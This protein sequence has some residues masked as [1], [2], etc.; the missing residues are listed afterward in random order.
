MK[1]VPQIPSPPY[2]PV[3]T[4]NRG[5]RSSTQDLLR[6]AAA[7]P[8]E[9]I[10]TWNP[11]LFEL[12]AHEWAF[13]CVQPK[14]GKV[15]WAA[16]SGDKGRDIRAYVIDEQ[17]E[18][19]SY[20]CKRYANKL[21]PSEAWIEL[22]KLC[23]YSY[24]GPLNGGYRCPRKFYFVAQHGVGQS[25]QDLIEAPNLLMDGLIA[26]WNDKCREKITSTAIELEGKLLEYVRQFPFQI[27]SHRTPR[28][29]VKDIEDTPYYPWFF[30][31]RKF[32]RDPI[33]PI[34]DAP[35]AIETKYVRALIHAY[36]EHLKCSPEGFGVT[37][38][39]PHEEIK[40]H[41]RESRE[42]FFYA[43]QLLRLGRDTFPTGT[44][45]DIL[46]QMYHGVITTVRADYAD[47]YARVVAVTE[48]AGTVVIGGNDLGQE[49]K[50]QDRTGLCHY[51]ANEGELKWVRKPKTETPND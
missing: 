37:H 46:K 35:I 2:V 20:Q 34:P 5:V 31:F 10:S 24:L 13:S 9:V 7:H 16:G 29:L 36:A 11:D 50:V 27:V 47:G 8:V 19:D 17:G 42:C 14:Y 38:L 43:E 48:K 23:Y 32:V 4:P 18:W 40:S 15:V 6:R 41:F 39:E 25:L 33:G 1:A 26:C 22:G 12:F 49:L 45:T 28:E 3:P 21:A 44:D 30:G 51:L